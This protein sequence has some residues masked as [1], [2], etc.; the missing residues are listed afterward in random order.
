MTDN[1]IRRIWCNLIAAV[2]SLAIIVPITYMITD[3]DLPVTLINGRISPSSVYTGQTVTITWYGKISRMCEGVVYRR[4]VDSGGFIIDTKLGRAES[5]TLLEGKG[6]GD[7]NKTAVIP[8]MLPGP[9]TY[10]V[11]TSYWCNP[12]QKYIWPI[13]HAEDLIHFTVLKTE[14]P[15]GPKGDQGPP[16][17]RGESGQSR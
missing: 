2:F 17:E 1:L 3:R 8:P 7:F 12:F 14:L 9:A 4:V 10:Q 15:A 6:Y 11:F 16:G 13:F 5:F